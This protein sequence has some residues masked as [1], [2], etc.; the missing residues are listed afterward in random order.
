MQEE[1]AALTSGGAREIPV[2]LISRG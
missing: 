1:K 2:F